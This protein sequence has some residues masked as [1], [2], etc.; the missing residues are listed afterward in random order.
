MQCR[1]FYFESQHYVH[2][3]IIR[4]KSSYI[5]DMPLSISLFVMDFHLGVDEGFN[6][7]IGLEIIHRFVQGLDAGIYNLNSIWKRIRIGH[8]VWHGQNVHCFG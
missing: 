3:S 7:L 8:I 2:L 6:E 4:I 5:D 1:S